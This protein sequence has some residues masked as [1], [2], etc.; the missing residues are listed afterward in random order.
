MVFRL[1]SLAGWLCVSLLFSDRAWGIGEVTYEVDGIKLTYNLG[2][3]WRSTNAKQPGV[4]S[5]KAD[6]AQIPFV[7][8]TDGSFFSEHRTMFSGSVGR[9]RS[10]ISALEQLPAESRRGTVAKYMFYPKNKPSVISY[11]VVGQRRWLIST[12]F[13]DAEKQFVKNQTYWGLESGLLLTFNIN[14]T[15]SAPRDARWRQRR[16]QTLQHLVSTFRVTRR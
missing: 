13:D 4:W 2:P 10:R 3:I 9:L 14:F 15:E 8:L 5:L 16:L 11:A 12:K 7:A 6:V 1:C